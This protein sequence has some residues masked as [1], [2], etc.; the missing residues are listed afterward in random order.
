MGPAQDHWC[1]LQVRSKITHGT[2]MDKVLAGGT[3]EA[4]AHLTAP[5]PVQWFHLHI[6]RTPIHCHSTCAKTSLLLC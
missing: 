4:G 2:E 3:Q 6:S 1:E 5:Q